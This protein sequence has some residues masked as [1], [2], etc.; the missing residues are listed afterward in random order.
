MF[1]FFSEKTVFSKSV[2]SI[3]SGL[4]PPMFMLQYLPKE[5]KGHWAKEA[6]IEAHTPVNFN[7]NARFIHLHMSLLFQSLQ[8]GAALR[9]H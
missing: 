9:S 6:Y 4:A 5:L 8:M 7:S 3:F 1:F 2:F